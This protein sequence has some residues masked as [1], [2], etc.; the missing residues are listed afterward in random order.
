LFAIKI[1]SPL[2]FLNYITLPLSWQAKYLSAIENIEYLQQQ[3]YS[4]F[5]QEF[6][7]L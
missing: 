7:V 6:D 3:I 2:F 4:P 1:A 5:L